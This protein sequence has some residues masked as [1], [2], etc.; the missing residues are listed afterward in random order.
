M[1]AKESMGAVIRRLRTEKGWTQEALADRLHLTPQAVSRWETEQ[2]LPDVSQVPQLARAFGVTTDTL[3]GLEAP[4]EDR[5]LL[6]SAGLVYV[7]WDPARALGHWE[8]M[9]E[10]LRAGDLGREHSNFRWTFLSLSRKLADPESPV[11]A[12]ER[13]EEVRRAALSLGRDFPRQEEDRFLQDQL[14][15]DL[16]R[17]C[18]L[19]GQREA[20]FDR[21]GEV[22]FVELNQYRPAAQGELW[23]LLGERR[24]ERQ[25]LN[26]LGTQAV[27]FLLDTLYDAGDNALAAGE[28]GRALE[29]ASLALR[30]IPLFCGRE[31]NLPPLHIR[32]RGDFYGLLA[33]S[34][35]ALGDG[36]GALAA[37]GEMTDRRHSLLTGEEQKVEN[38][39]LRSWP[40][41]FHSSAEGPRYHRA[42]LRRELGKPELKILMDTPEG[43]ALRERAEA[44]PAE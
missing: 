13:A 23:R 36:E 4:E 17:L 22:G 8:K 39:L 43:A 35:A 27:H 2:S 20:A 5:E 34:K 33:R 30:L 16:A 38:V 11:Y 7:D 44:I 40:N 41:S 26:S 25:A 37:L 15:R 19:D 31:T 29:A 18:A 1:E 10:R 3:Y 32:E 9:A 24:Q 28:A 6:V 12:P 21:L 14:R 42:L